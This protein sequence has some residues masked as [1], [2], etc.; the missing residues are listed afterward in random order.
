MDD[1]GSAPRCYQS[2]AHGLSY[3]LSQQGG[4]TGLLGSGRSRR[5][6]PNLRQPAH[7]R[8]LQAGVVIGRHG[9]LFWWAV[10]L[11]AWGI[12]IWSNLVVRQIRDEPLTTA[13]WI[14]T[15]GG[16]C[17]FVLTIIVVAL[18]V[19]ASTIDSLTQ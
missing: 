4:A 8:N 13:R 9:A 5:A 7:C 2:T 3:I 18:V 11:V 6:L 10:L 16:T 15:G 1:L 19:R 12:L 17:F 14:P